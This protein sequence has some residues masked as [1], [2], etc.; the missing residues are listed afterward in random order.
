[1][2]AAATRERTKRRAAAKAKM[3]RTRKRVKRATK[4]G[5]ARLPVRNVN[6][7]HTARLGLNLWPKSLVVGGKSCHQKSWKITRSVRRRI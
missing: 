5:M 2:T 4:V 1:M 3:A 7:F 6:G